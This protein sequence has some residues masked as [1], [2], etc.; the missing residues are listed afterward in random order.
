MSHFTGDDFSGPRSPPTSLF[1]VIS[2]RHKKQARV[3]FLK[4]FHWTMPLV[5]AATLFVYANG[6]EGPFLFDDSAHITQNQWV[7][8]ESLSW[9]NLVQAWNSS[10]SAFPTNRPLAQLS[11]GINHALAGLSPWA[12]KAT[13]LA[14][15]LLT[16]LLVFVLSQLIYRAVAGEAADP[17]RGRLLAAATA[18]VWLLHPLHVSTVL[19]TVQRMA[20]LSSLGLLAALSCY[21]WGRIRIAEGRPGALWILAS[22][23]I[24]MLGF[25][26]KENAALLPLLLLVSEITVLQNLPTKGRSGFM[27]TVWIL[28]IA[29]PLLASFAYFAT[30]PGYLNFDGRPF[31]LE[32]R[33]L[34]QARVLWL[35]LQWL[36]VPDITAMGLFHDDLRLSTGLASPPSTAIAVFALLGITL[37]ALSLRRKTPVFAFAV[38]FFLAA[39]ALE[40]SV[41]P[42]EIVFEHRNYLAS[43]G[44]LFLFAY[45]VTIASQRMKVRSLA[46][47][48]GTL[49]L[50]SYSAVTYIRVNNWSS[51]NSF[52][53]SSAENHPNSPRSNFMAAQLTISALSNSEGGREELADAARTFLNRGLEVDPRC[54]NCL[55]ALIVLE[56]H[57]DRQPNAAILRQLTDTLRVG[58]VGPTKVSI[59]QFS[60]LVNWQRSDAVKLRKEDLEAIFEAALA[61]PAWNNTGRAGIETAYREYYEFVAKDLEAALPHAQAAVRLW[62]EPWKYRMNLAR[63]LLKL[64]RTGEALA[65]LDGAARAADN[66]AQQAETEEV[67]AGIGRD[68]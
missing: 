59:S 60:F 11:F 1:A 58:D 31:T 9:D 49:L 30:H 27:R 7:K 61:N 14:I 19:Y 64:G 4:A 45:L 8:I 35:Y 37:A 43:L 23:P 22:A 6:L 20:Q 21:F 24:A 57:L 5:L 16:G 54:L 26:A 25:L 62:P 15:H 52:I 63:L 32:E 50:L 17:R 41:F 65:A 2:S 10:F 12:F 38:L 33:V 51:Y 42:L 47:T 56:L 18:A 48:L 53:L 68:L 3:P 44:P 36:F 28:F 13:N 67:R 55:F 40:S 66:E 34:T 46:M 39:H 29:V